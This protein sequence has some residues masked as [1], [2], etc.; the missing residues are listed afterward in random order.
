MIVTAA[1]ARPT[2]GPFRM[3][4]HARR[5]VEAAGQS[6]WFVTHLADLREHYRHLPTLIAM[7]DMGPASPDAQA[8]ATPRHGMLQPPTSVC[9]S[10]IPAKPTPGIEPGTSALP[11][12]RSAS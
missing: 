3:L 7:F 5:A 12:R 6:E 8:E 4:K 9:W 11:W 1:A 2:P 10:G